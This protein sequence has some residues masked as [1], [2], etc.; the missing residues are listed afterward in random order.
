MN[1]FKQIVKEFYIPLILSVSWV[2]YNIYGGSNGTE[3]TT[4]KVVNVFGPT[5]FLLSWLTGQFFRV[6]KQT[7]VENSFGAMESRFKELLEKVEAKT[8]EMIGH[9]SGGNSFP[10]FQVSMIDNS[11]NIGLLMAMHQ[12]KHP[13]YDVSARIVDLNKFE[14]V[15]T[16]FSLATLGYTDTN[17][18]LGNMTS[19]NVRLVQQWKLESEPEQSY[20][21]FFTARNGSFIQELRLKK[22]YGVWVSATKISNNDNVVL[23]EQI[24]KSYPKNSKGIVSW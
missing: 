11:T 21:I 3:W 6:K 19:S 18:N 16:K 12:G 7:R 4:Q 9:I 14:Q 22:I 1:I 23:Y 24:D 17:I 2:L 15:K 10:W 13:L 20:N 8:E 5:F